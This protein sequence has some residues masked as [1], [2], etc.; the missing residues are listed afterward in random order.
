MSSAVGQAPGEGLEEPVGAAGDDVGSGLGEGAVVDRV[1]QVV[2][3]LGRRH[4]DPGRDVDAEG[5]GSVLLLGQDAVGAGDAEVADLDAVGDA[6]GD[7]VPRVG[8][9]SISAR[10]S[11]P[12]AP[13]ACPT[14]CSTRATAWGR[15]PMR[16]DQT[17]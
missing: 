4:V 11:R 7:G 2:G 14:T 16:P 9:P 5:L 3:L 13:M 17:R 8:M 12:G 6:H 10:S 15:L 1:G